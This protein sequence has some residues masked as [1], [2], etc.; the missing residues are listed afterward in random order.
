[1]HATFLLQFTPLITLM[2]FKVYAFSVNCKKVNVPHNRPEGPEGSRGLD[3]L[4]LDLGARSGGWSAPSPGR[5]TPGK[6]RYPLYRML[7]GPRA[8]LD[9]CEKSRPHRVLISGPSSP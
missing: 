6:T 1:V 5:F 9:V 7:G 4:F 3:L 8:G 2:V